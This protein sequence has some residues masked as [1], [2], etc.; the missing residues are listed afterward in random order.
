MPF[1]SS[2]PEPTERE[3]ERYRKFL[4]TA[5]PDNGAA[6]NEMAAARAEAEKLEASFPSIRLYKDEKKSSPPPPPPPPKNR[7]DDVLRFVS[8]FMD[9]VQ[10]SLSARQL[11]FEETE[12][13]PRVLSDG[14]LRVSV[15][16][17]E[18]GFEDAIAMSASDRTLFAQAAGELFVRNLLDT[19]RDEDEAR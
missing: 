10:N 6:P 17:S 1:A 16:I 3:I 4:R 8:G 14:R 15:T 7:V 19:L 5:N 2:C 11:A 18:G 12:V 9:N 13:S